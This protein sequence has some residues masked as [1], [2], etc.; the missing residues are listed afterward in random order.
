L[1]WVTHGLPLAV[2]GLGWG[3]DAGA[4]NQNALDCQSIEEDLI[5]RFDMRNLP[6]SA[7]LLAIGGN[8]QT[9]G[10]PCGGQ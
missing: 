10:H 5:A 9:A 1:T 4:F 3:H 2:G 6:A 7:S 8:M